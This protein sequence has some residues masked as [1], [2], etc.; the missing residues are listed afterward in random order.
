MQKEIVAIRVGSIITNNR[1]EIV[2]ALASHQAYEL[3]DRKR[4]EFMD[5]C[6]LGINWHKLATGPTL[7]L[8]EYNEDNV[9][10]DVHASQKEI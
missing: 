4:M 9:L 6:D 10:V 7:F 1:Q 3:L 2:V 8:A 5:M